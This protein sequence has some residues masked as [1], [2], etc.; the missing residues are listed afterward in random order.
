[1][2]SVNRIAT[3]VLWLRLVLA[4][5][6]GIATAAIA[7]TVRAGV[8]Q[9]G[10]I[11]VTDYG[12]ASPSG[13]SDGAL[14]KVDSITGAR[15]ILSGRGIGTG[16]ML[17]DP[18]GVAVERSGSILVTDRSIDSASGTHRGFVYRVDPVSGDRI[19][20]SGPN[21]GHGPPLSGPLGPLGIVVDQD[22]SIVVADVTSEDS[23]PN[24][25]AVLR[26]DPTNGDRQLV[27]GLGTGIGPSLDYPVGI[28]VAENGTIFVAD[29]VAHMVHTIEPSSGNR[30]AIGSL[31]GFDGVTDVEVIGPHTLLINEAISGAIYVVDIVTGQTTLV[32]G[33]GLTS[34]VGD[35]PAITPVGVGISP[36]SDAFYTSC[37]LS[38]TPHDAIVQIDWS[39][40][41][42]TVLSGGGIGAGPEFNTLGLMTVVSVPEPPTNLT[43]G[44]AI[45]T[46]AVVR[47]SRFLR[48]KP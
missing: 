46:F 23:T 15:T 26:I 39:S 12:M 3:V 2:G 24:P 31:Q 29:P 47:W 11:L 30:V 4:I 34:I 25:G 36:A 35:G 27:S 33:P 38:L 6:S 13:P 5:S 48:R 41:D 14:F 42:R 44:L 7:P 20:I 21:R 18:F 9:T 16:P 37:T 32:S 40:G 28:A 22:G 17:I 43:F 1:M 10:D 45:A 19:E 8:L